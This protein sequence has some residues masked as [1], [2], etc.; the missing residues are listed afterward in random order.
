MRAGRAEVIL[1]DIGGSRRAVVQFRAVQ[2]FSVGTSGFPF[3]AVN[4]FI[5]FGSIPFPMAFTALFV[6]GLE[7]PILP[8]LLFVRFG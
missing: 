6:A 7:L 4:G 2:P 8:G 5:T 3:R 1:L